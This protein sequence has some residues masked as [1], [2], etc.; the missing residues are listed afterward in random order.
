MKPV[1]GDEVRKDHAF[2]IDMLGGGIRLK[3]GCV[4]RDGVHID[5]LGSPLIGKR[6]VLFA[7]KLN[8]AGDFGLIK[9]FELRDGR[10]FANDS[11]ADRIISTLPGVP[12][13]WG[14]E[15]QFISALRQDIQ[16]A[17]VEDPPNLKPTK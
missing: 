16:T 3:S 15:A 12:K 4:V 13:Q 17:G 8:S 7:P 2:V 9:S 14:F 11:R 6:Y 10:V 5:G 1:S